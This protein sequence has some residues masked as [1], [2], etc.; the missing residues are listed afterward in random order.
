MTKTNLEKIRKEL[1]NGFG[2]KTMR[3]GIEYAWYNAG[4]LDAGIETRARNA[5]KWRKKVLELGERGTVTQQ[6]VKLRLRYV[7]RTTFFATAYYV[8]DVLE[9]YVKSGKMLNADPDNWEIV[10]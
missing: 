3:N 7:K 4:A 8:D 10:S 1:E 9:M 6:R 5:R 2:K